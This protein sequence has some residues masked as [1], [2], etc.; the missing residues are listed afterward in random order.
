ML[1][2]LRSYSRE[3]HL[4]AEHLI[5]IK[6]VDFGFGRNRVLENINLE[7]RR[8]DFLAVLGPNG[9]GKTTL[10]KLILGLYQPGA[11]VIELFGVE[12]SRFR[13]R[14][15]IGYVP[16]KTGAFG[17]FPATVWEIVATGRT[18]RI[19]LWRGLGVEDREKIRAALSALGLE[20][21]AHRPVGALS[22]G[23]RQRVAIA[24]ALAA[25][26]EVLLLDEAAEGLDAAGEDS[27][28][29]LLERF[30]REQGLT[31]VLVTHDIGAV[32]RRVKKVVCLNRCIVFE[33]PPQ[34]CLENGKLSALYRMPVYI[35]GVVN[36]RQGR[37]TARSRR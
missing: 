26:P 27:F 30:N 15:R 17:E 34:E 5:R 10:L 2:A 12:G 28:Y 14:H 20:E 8:G 6:G 23:Q 13:E 31:V 4:T 37:R 3:E 35:P 29:G 22:G 24:R 11:G 36:R 21:L 9:A 33:G 18:A 32:S 25:E 7:I 1:K 19:G 16:Q